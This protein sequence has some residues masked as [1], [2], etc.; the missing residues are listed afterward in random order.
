M[1][2]NPYLPVTTLP[3]SAVGAGGARTEGVKELG[4]VGSIVGPAL[5]VGD[6]VGEPELCVGAVVSDGFSLLSAQPAVEAPTVKTAITL[7]ASAIRRDTS[8]DFIM[9]HSFWMT[10]VARNLSPAPSISA[11]TSCSE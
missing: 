9:P 3:G 7:S 4:P 10:T 5:L 8:V 2:G 1:A 6:G 11:D